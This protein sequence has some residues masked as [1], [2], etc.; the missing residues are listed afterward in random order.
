[1]LSLLISDLDYQMKQISNEE[2]LMKVSASEIFS[3]VHNDCI[4]AIRSEVEKPNAVE[5][6][7]QSKPIFVEYSCPV[8][9]DIGSASVLVSIFHKFEVHMNGSRAETILEFM[10]SLLNVIP[11]ESNR[12]FHDEESSLKLKIFFKKGIDVSIPTEDMITSFLLSTDFVYFDNY[13]N[14]MTRSNE[15]TPNEADVDFGPTKNSSMTSL[16]KLSRL[17]LIIKANNNLVLPIISNPI[18]LE[19]YADR[20]VKCSDAHIILSEKRIMGLSGCVDLI[21]SIGFYGK[22]ADKSKKKSSHINPNKPKANQV[23]SLTCPNITIACVRDEEKKMDLSLQHRELLV[24]EILLD[25]M[26]QISCNLVGHRCIDLDCR[27]IKIS[28]RFCLHRLEAAGMSKDES[29]R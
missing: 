17:R 29:K 22:S 15:K 12:K 21:T 18:D 3:F 13:I 6:S 28:S 23:M 14:K 10:T 2:Y 25:L 8:L 24:K 4:L 16:F 19:M 11:Y 1:M 20:S 7:I 9:P 26:S 27:S 5:D